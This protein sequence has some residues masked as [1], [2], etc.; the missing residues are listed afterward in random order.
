M[1]VIA[2]SKIHHGYRIN[3]PQEIVQYYDIDESTIV[4]WIIDEN[5]ELKL[6]FKKKSEIKKFINAFSFDKN[7]NGLNFK[8]DFYN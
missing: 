2:N 6:N 3:I 1:A 7:V 4:E 8:R 5:D